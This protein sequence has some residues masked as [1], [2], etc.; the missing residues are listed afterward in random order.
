MLI[1]IIYGVVKKL[2]GSKNGMPP[3]ESEPEISEEDVECPG[4]KA[5]TFDSLYQPT[6]TFV[7]ES[8]AKSPVSLQYL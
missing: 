3:L 7:H 8:V 4:Q 2:L 6:S 5:G 1:I